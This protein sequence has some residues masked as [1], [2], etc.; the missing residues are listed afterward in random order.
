M[1]TFEMTATEITTISA[2][3]FLALIQA[4]TAW[5]QK[6][7]AGTVEVVHQ[8]VNS[9]LGEQLKIGMVSALTLANQTGLAEH[10]ALATVA[11]D[12]YNLHMAD[13]AKVDAEIKS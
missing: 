13:Q 2:A 5:Q 4:W 7:T 6:K 3:I 11:A 8:L 10:R 9:N 12:K 1:E